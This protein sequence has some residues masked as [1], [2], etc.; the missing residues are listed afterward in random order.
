M[1]RFS[2]ALMIGGG[3]LASMAFLYA[4]VIVLGRL[5]Y[6]HLTQHSTE[7]GKGR[8]MAAVNERE[9]RIPGR[10]TKRLA[11]GFSVTVNGKRTKQYR[12]EWSKEDAEKEL[13]T[14][15][16]RLKQ[17]PAVPVVSGITLA[18]AAER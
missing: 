18:Q 8:A 12:S 1:F 11:W 9:G 15:M 6:G 7:G 5:S 14:V 17:Q 13:A 4:L 3:V 16:L 10:R 2:Y